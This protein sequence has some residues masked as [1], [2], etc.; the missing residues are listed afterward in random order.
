[1]DEANHPFASIEKVLQDEKRISYHNDY[2]TS[3]LSAIRYNSR[4]IGKNN[5]ST[6]LYFCILVL[7]IYHIIL[8]FLNIGPYWHLSWIHDCQV[9]VQESHFFY[10]N[11]SLFFNCREDG[12]KVRGYF[13]WSLLDNWEW[14]SGYTV[15][16]GLY[17]IDYKNNLT[18]IP[19]ASVQWF[20][21]FLQVSESKLDFTNWDR[22]Y[23]NM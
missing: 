12:C 9:L 13:V 11:V 7:F 19:K 6:I 5:K 8:H 17:Y 21:Q 10:I 4:L 22:F 3:L 23:L 16:F 2:L 1:M 20:K 14:N 15:R 18:R